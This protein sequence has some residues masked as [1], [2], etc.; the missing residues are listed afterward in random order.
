MT[1]QV[2][3][4]ATSHDTLGTTGYPTGV[5][6][7]EVAHPFDA[8]TRAGA[9][10][11]L[12]TLAGGRPPIDPFSDPGTE[13]S[14]TK[15]DEVTKRFLAEQSGLLDGAAKLSE[16]ELENYDAIVFAGGNGAIFDFPES[17]DVKRSAETIWKRGGI[18]S[19][20]CH[21]S[22]ALLGVEADGRPLI[23]GQSVTGFSNRE[24]HMAEEQIGQKYMPFYLQDALI[25]KGG[26][27]S[28]GDP[29]T[30]YLTVAREGRLIT[31]Q[32]NFSGG[33]VG[34]AVAKALGL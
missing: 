18:V 11:H 7:T 12:A 13:V 24:E 5:W 4:V 3:V 2:L 14:K 25:E 20:L 26:R 33:L 21:G 31:G 22:A 9:S 23:E 16:V 6:L 15:D 29:F 30:P 8:L 28:E 17:R 32:N 34:E 27:Y 19:A 10:V 1:K